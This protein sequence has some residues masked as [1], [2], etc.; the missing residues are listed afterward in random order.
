[1]DPEPSCGGDSPRVWGL[2][3]SHAGRPPGHSAALASPKP[4][5]PCPAARRSRHCPVARRHRDRHHKGAQAQQQTIFCIDEAGFY[6]LPRVV[7]TDAPIGQTPILHEWW[8]RAHLSAISALSPEGK[9][10]FHSPAQ[11]FNSEDVVAV[12]EHW[13]REV[14]GRMV[15]IWDGAPI[16]RSHPIREFLSTGASPRIHLERRPA[17]APDL[18]PDEGVWQQLNGVELRHVCCCELPPLRGELRDAVNRVRR[19]P[20]SLR[21]FF[22]GAGLELFLHGS[23]VPIRGGRVSRR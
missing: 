16:H 14:P 11:A 7:R 13:L 6:P 1:M 10:S 4:R 20:R 23:V 17:Y 12:L 18:N 9:L 21:G 15:L 19:K 22:Q 8:T 3:A 5:P 2:L